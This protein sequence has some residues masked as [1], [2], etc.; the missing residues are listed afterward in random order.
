M[1][2]DKNTF[3]KRQRETRKRQKA[4]D[5]R[6]RRRKRREGGDRLETAGSAP[7]AG[8]ATDPL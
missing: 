6:V 5:K 4:E 1:K 2:R 8:E 3:E 7:A